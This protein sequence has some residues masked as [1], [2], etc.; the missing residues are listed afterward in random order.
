MRKPKFEGTEFIMKRIFFNYISRYRL[1][2]TPS[3][4]NATLAVKG[5]KPLLKH[6]FVLLHIVVG[7]VTPNWVRLSIIILKRFELIGKKQGTKGLVKFL[8]TL[9]V[10]IQQV[11]GGHVLHD[12]TPLGPRIS[13]TKSGIPRVLPV[14]VRD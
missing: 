7:K 4:F 3:T 14:A 2:L 10:L 12:V 9:T 1:D 6:I 13:R 8:K 11:I 5:W